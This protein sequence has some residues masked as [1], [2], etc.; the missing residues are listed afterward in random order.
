MNPAKSALVETNDV[1]RRFIAGDRRAFDE[2]Y[3]LYAPSVLSFLAARTTSHQDAED[4]LHTA[5]I[6]AQQN[7]GSFDGQ[8]FRAWFFQI[9]RNTLFDFT[10]S[11]RTKS[12]AARID[13]VSEPGFECD[14]SESTSRDDE[15][16]ALKDC[17][18]SVGGAFVEAVVR[19]QLNDESP[20]QLAQEIGKARATID[21]R[22]SR[23]KQQLRECLEKKLK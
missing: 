11:P 7:A 2:L 9:A 20:E 15:I 12:K 3:R 21:S 4:L 10:K 14:P 6:K 19:T 22:V 8:N 23:G 18:Q 1:I 17:I 16:Q 13:D 5:W